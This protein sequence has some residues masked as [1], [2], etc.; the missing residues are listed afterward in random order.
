MMALTITSVGHQ[1]QLVLSQRAPR[2]ARKEVDGETD[3]AEAEA[4]FRLEGVYASRLFHR[5]CVFHTH[6][7][8][9]HT[10]EEKQEVWEDCCFHT[11]LRVRN[12]GV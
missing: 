5:S 11:N 6:D 4:V 8:S 10:E 9:W 1:S 2:S 12:Q 3:Q 7:G